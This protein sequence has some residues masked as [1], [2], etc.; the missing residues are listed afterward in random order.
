MSSPPRSGSLLATLEHHARNQPGQKIRF[1]GQA[2]SEELTYADLWRESNHLAATLAG[3]G[4]AAGTRAALPMA[5]RRAT[6][7]A[8]LALFRLGATL[9]PLVHQPRLRPGKPQTRSALAALRLGRVSHLLATADELD[10]WTELLAAETTAVSGVAIDPT[11]PR[12]TDHLPPHT[13]TRPSILQFSS[14]ST[15]DPKGIW[16]EE[17]HLLACV[18]GIIE[19][20]SVHPGDRFLS[21][22]PLFHD[23]GLIGFLFTPLRIGAE[24][25]LWPSQQFIRNPL[26][27]VEALTRYR[28]TITCG[29][30]FSYNL[31]LEKSLRDGDEPSPELDLSSLRLALNGSESVHYRSSQR[32]QRHFAQAGLRPGTVLACYGL[33]ENCLAVTLRQP[34]TPM[35]HRHFER[36][37]LARGRAELAAEPGPTTVT[38]AANGWPILGTEVCC[39]DEHGQQVELPHIGEIHFRGTAATPAFATGDGELRPSSNDGWVA[40]GDLGVEIDGELYIVGRVKELFKRG[41]R[42]YAPTDIEISLLDQPEVEA[43]GIAAVA[44]PDPATGLDELVLFVELPPRHPVGDLPGRLRL[45]VLRDYQLPIR[46]VIPVLR[47]SLPKTT[48][49]KIQRVALGHAYAAGRLDELVRRHPAGD[50]V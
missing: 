48:S 36:E 38:L 39:R 28:T 8:I 24:F 20:L 1:L 31:C 33:A 23:M 41:G 7:V 5:S 12:D 45:Q 6:V 11:E 46:E 3:C 43:G 4:I 35:A 17:R 10:A 19:R 25:T 9:V 34:L 26:G 2:K 21:W 47:H 22:L 29:P 42:T 40:T 16:L 44:V 13:E 14:G 32:F 49:G 50:V 27:W 15:A 18:D 37:A 30:Q